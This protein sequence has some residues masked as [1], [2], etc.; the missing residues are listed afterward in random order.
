MKTKKTKPK[1][2]G[3]PPN[4]P[5]ITWVGLALRVRR[6]SM[7]LSAVDLGL[8][9]GVSRS[10]IHSWESEDYAPS[11]DHVAAL[12]ERLECRR[13]YFSKTPRLPKR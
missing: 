10:A 7:G 5:G 1:I 11:A 12:A 8:A 13:S 6:I 9:I 2:K 3:R 4:D